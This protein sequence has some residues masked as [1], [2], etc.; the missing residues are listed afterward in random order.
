M[1]R[2]ST[3]VGR[4]F[5]AR[6]AEAMRR[7]MYPNTGLQP[8]QLAGIVGKSA[9]SFMRWCRG[10]ARVPADVIDPLIAFFKERG[11]GWFLHELFPSAEA[12]AARLDAELVEL[13]RR[14]DR[15]HLELKGAAHGPKVVLAGR[16]DD[17]AAAG[18]MVAAPVGVG[19]AQEVAAR[20]LQKGA[21]AC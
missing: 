12:T 10:E 21:P 2:S 6:F 19:Q 5:A 11:D 20:P 13:Q 7:R 18:D 14:L 17:L 16:P 8:K 3:E 15:L 1:D 4:S 9:D